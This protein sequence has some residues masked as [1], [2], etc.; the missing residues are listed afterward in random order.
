M[1]I[2]ATE[3]MKD[4]KTGKHIDI[5][6]HCKEQDDDLFW[7]GNEVEYDDFGLR[8]CQECMDANPEWKRTWDSFPNY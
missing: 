6:P 7:V 1:K 8:C 3:D 4:P 5:C 2:E